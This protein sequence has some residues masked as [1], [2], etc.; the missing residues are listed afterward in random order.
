MNDILNHYLNVSREEIEALG[1]H[2]L[3]QLTLA[4]LTKQNKA[5]DYN[6]INRRAF[7]RLSYRSFSAVA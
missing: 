2:A 7:S 3:K 4:M 5:L 1:I 6:A